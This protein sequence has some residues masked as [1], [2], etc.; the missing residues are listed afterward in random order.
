M[1]IIKNL[2]EI[3]LKKC[4]NEILLTVERRVLAKRRWRGQADDGTDFGFDLTS[5]LRNG[6]CFHKQENRNYV[7]DQ[8][9]ESVFKIPY[10]NPNEAA[11]WAWQVG[12]LHFP[13]QFQDAY[14]LVEGDYAVRLMLE[15]NQIPFDESTEVFQPVMAASS[16]HHGN[17][18]LL[19]YLN[20]W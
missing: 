11:H 4:E 5:P 13:A 9:P 7:I 8:K 14:L 18:K 12:N 6:I 3:K 1:I 16:H 10:S 15:R 20:M 2:N 17:G 19:K